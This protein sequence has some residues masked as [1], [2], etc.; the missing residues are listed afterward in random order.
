[1]ISSRQIRA[2]RALLGWSQQELADRAIVSMNAVARIERGQVD[3][4]VS[5]IVAIERTLNKAGV[6]FLSPG[7]RGE[8]VRMKSPKL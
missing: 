2:A 6:E 3:A 4:R 8:G 1:M 5:T 7:D